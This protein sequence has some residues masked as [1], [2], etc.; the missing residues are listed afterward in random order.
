MA[1]AEK[2]TSKWPRR[3]LRLALAGLLL[4]AAA[5][6]CLSGR[7]LPQIARPLLAEEEIGRPDYLC[8]ADDELDHVYDL[9]ATIYRSS[10]CQVLLTPTRRRRLIDIGVREKP[11]VVAAR[12]LRSRGV[13]PEAI[14]ILARGEG[15]VTTWI[16]R[17]PSARVVLL[18]KRFRSA[19]RRKAL[20]AAL[21]PA[22][23]A[24]VV[25]RGVRDRRYDETNWWRSRLGMKE[26][27]YAY[28]GAGDA[29]TGDRYDA[30]QYE[31]VFLQGIGVQP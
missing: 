11:E 30:D 28:L 5:G 22:L 1:H 27:F 19:E 12:A 21:G 8:I 10:R 17:H 26:L 18:C 4:A 29:G 25:V 2:S 15:T 7:I 9:A 14:V 23:A 13:P 6:W 31:K 24:R 16:G 3:S 20:D